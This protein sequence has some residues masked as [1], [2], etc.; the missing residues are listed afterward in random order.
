MGAIG[1]HHRRG[2]PDKD[3]RHKTSLDT[4]HLAKI[5]KRSHAQQENTGRK[6][7]RAASLLHGGGGGYAEGD[8]EGGARE[9]EADEELRR[10]FDKA[11]FKRMHVIG[12]FNLGFLVCRLGR[13]I[14][15]VDQHASDEIFNFERLQAHTKLN[16][17]PLINPVPLEMSPVEQL[18][19]S[20]NLNIFHKNGFDIRNSGS[21]VPC[22]CAVPYSKNTVF[23]ADGESRVQ[24]R[25][26]PSIGFNYPPKELRPCHTLCALL[27]KP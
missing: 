24:E 13:D 27:R 17:Q 25:K 12:Q 21:F 19:V 7:F 9:A 6:K 8:A 22:M 26:G 20:D 1:H 2:P 10:V 16:R 15:I 5:H 14:F 18:M 3:T 4:P 11:D 23:G